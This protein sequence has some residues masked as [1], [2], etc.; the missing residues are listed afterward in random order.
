MEHPSYGPAYMASPCMPVRSSRPALAISRLS[1]TSTAR[2]L[3]KLERPFR[4]DPIVVH[5]ILRYVGL[6]PEPPPW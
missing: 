2:V 5:R 3:Y 1:V 6:G 4:D